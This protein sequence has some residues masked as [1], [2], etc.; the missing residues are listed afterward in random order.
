MAKN[1]FQCGGWNYNI[2]QCGTII[3]LIRQ[4]T[5]PCNMACG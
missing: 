4:V 3:T 5:A 2:L 1:D